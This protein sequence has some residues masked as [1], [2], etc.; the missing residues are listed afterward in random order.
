MD[1]KVK[2]I[3]VEIHGY[4]GDFDG[5]TDI[6]QGHY[7]NDDHVEVTKEEYDALV[8]YVYNINQSYGDSVKYLILRGQSEEESAELM[9]TAYDKLKEKVEKQK[10]EQAKREAAAKK[11]A[12]IAQQKKEERE[13]KKL[14]ELKKKFGEL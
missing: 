9:K 7:L 3:V 2:I 6:L 5:I 10:K 13:R 1:N 12:K 4:Y 14:E 8:D 11:K